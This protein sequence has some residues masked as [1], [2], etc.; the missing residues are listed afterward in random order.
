MWRENEF[1]RSCSLPRV[2]NAVKCN[3]SGTAYL[4]NQFL[5]AQTLAI[6]G[7]G[8]PF[9]K[10]IHVG[11]IWNAFKLDKLANNFFSITR[12]VF[13]SHPDD[14]ITGMQIIQLS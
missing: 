7:P 5:I 11:L 13:A 8:I 12:I 10:Q 9:D 3:F 2:V 4:A 14:L 6:A 1:Y